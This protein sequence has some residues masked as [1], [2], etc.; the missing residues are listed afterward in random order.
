M[1]M[2]TRYFILIGFCVTCFSSKAG[3][4]NKIDSLFVHSDKLTDSL[5][6]VGIKSVHSYYASFAPDSALEVAKRGL[7][8]ARQRGNKEFEADMHIRLGST[9]IDIGDYPKAQSHFTNALRISESIGYT[10]AIPI[11]CNNMGIVY[12]SNKDYDKA[13]EYYSKAIQS[14]SLLKDWIGVGIDL[15]NLSEILLL[16]SNPQKAKQNY[17][18]ALSICD[19]FDIEP[20]KPSVLNNLGEVCLY[21]EQYDSALFYLE[22]AVDLKQGLDMEIKLPVSLT[23]IGRI[24]MKQGKYDDA[25]KAFMRSYEI[26]MEKGLVRDT[27]VACE[28][29]ANYFYTIGKYKLGFE[30][31]ERCS[32]LK[33]SVFNADKNKQIN[34]LEIRYQVDKKNQEI[35]L[36][37]AEVKF[38]RSLRN[39]GII[40]VMLTLAFFIMTYKRIK[41]RSQLLKKENEL[42]KEKS[43][44]LR[45]EIESKNRELLSKSMLSVQK[46]QT[47]NELKGQLLKMEG[48]SS[49]TQKALRLVDNNFSIDK[50]WEDLKIHFEKVHVGF[51]KNLQSLYPKLTPIDLRH[52]AYIRIQMSSKDVSRIMNVNPKSV[53]MTRYRLKKKFDLLP[54]ESLEAFLNNY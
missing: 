47:L 28:G 32:A 8:I 14:D 12:A 18:L 53:Q 29:L 48:E 49:E 19:K 15:S 44:Q 25:Y 43:K 30:Y 33:D 5:L 7:V 54:D 1:C 46:N 23:L 2:M 4:A 42:E 26:A 22:N 10:R 21:M 34:E 3:Y 11:I 52:C 9:F 38:Q 39:L 13:I 16:D 37:N 41:L 17:L 6:C 27:Q 35:E 40:L 31:A 51:F 50:D 45:Y 24:N 20:L 36:L